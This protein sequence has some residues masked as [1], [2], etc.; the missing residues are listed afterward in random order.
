[1]RNKK[2]MHEPGSQT[3]WNNYDGSVFFLFWKWFEVKQ[4]WIEEKQLSLRF[5][6]S[7]LKP[8]SWNDCQKVTVLYL[9]SF[10]LNDE[11]FTFKMSK[12]LVIGLKLISSEQ[13][14]LAFLA[15]LWKPNK[16]VLVFPENLV[17]STPWHNQFSTRDQFEFYAFYQ[18]LLRDKRI[19]IPY[20]DTFLVHSCAGDNGTERTTKSN[21]KLRCYNKT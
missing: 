2:C 12:S 7:K 18:F 11:N 6:G 9:S 21:T 10:K 4:T 8:E 5:I 14:W 3:R 17:G 20:V 19:E 15:W 16:V 1:M 13:F